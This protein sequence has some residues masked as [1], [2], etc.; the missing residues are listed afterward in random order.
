VKMLLGAICFI[1][2]H[3]CRRCWSVRGRENILS[4]WYRYAAKFYSRSLVME[5]IRRVIFCCRFA[6]YNDFQMW[7]IPG[8]LQVQEI[9]VLDCFLGVS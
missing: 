8:D 1:Y 7:G 5:K 6:E 2:S 4:M 9:E 3:L